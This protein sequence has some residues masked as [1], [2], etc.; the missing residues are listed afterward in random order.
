[1][2][3]IIQLFQLYTY[4]YPSLNYS[5]SCFVNIHRFLRKR[6]FFLHSPRV[7][8]FKLILCMHFCFL[9]FSYK[10]INPCRLSSYSSRVVI[11]YMC[12]FH[13]KMF[14]TPQGSLPVH[15]FLAQ[16]IY[17]CSLSTELPLRIV[18]IGKVSLI[19]IAFAAF[20]YFFRQ[21]VA[22]TVLHIRTRAIF[23]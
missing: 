15:L 2:K 3:K 13:H 19:R 16:H 12:Q 9:I 17:I 11:I 14:T 21:V 18:N 1:M 6:E 8:F 5:Y 20:F 23:Q 4:H 10:K 22:M 7:H